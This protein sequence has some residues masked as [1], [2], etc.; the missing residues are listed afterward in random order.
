MLIPFNV[1]V[2]EHVRNV[3]CDMIRSL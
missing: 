2:H 3:K 1:N